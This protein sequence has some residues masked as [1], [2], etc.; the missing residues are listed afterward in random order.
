[1]IYSQSYSWISAQLYNHESSLLGP[2]TSDFDSETCFG[3][4]M[5]SLTQVIGQIFE[6]NIFIASAWAVVESM[7]CSPL[8]CK[9]TLKSEYRSLSCRVMQK[10]ENACA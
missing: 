4:L 8:S 6:K 10:H 7:F 9:N 2:T 5:A 3:K 1:M